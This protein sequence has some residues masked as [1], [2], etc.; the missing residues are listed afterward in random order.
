VTVFPGNMAEYAN[1]FAS[2]LDANA[3]AREYKNV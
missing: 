3:I 1:G 2:D